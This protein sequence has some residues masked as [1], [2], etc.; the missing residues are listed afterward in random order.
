[1]YHLLITLK[2]Q[3]PRVSLNVLIELILG[4][5][6]THTAGAKNQEMA[7]SAHKLLGRSVVS[8]ARHSKVFP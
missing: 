6:C 2:R 8:I 4:M 1:M 3:I 5:S 7:L